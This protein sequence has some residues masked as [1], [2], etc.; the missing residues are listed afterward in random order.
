ELCAWSG[1][2]GAPSAAVAEARR[3]VLAAS[4][5][6]A[7]KVLDCFSGG[8]AIPLEVSRLGGEAYALELNPVAYLISLCTLV[9]PQTY[10][11]SLAADVEKWGKWLVDRARAEV[12]NLYPAIGSEP[13]QQLPLEPR[14]EQ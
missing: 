11:P 4:D 6:H 8:G 3:Q 9:Y 2:M 5:G 10:G 1:P 14:P 7:P 12:G 13:V